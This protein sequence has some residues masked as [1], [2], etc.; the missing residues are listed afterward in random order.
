MS[1]VMCCLVRRPRE[2]S[3]K[4]G[5]AETNNEGCFVFIF[6]GNPKPNHSFEWRILFE[7]RLYMSFIY[8]SYWI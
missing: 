3:T 6:G 4:S 8:T 2:G 5:Q 1:S 7:T